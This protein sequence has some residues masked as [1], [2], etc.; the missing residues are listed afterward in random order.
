MNPKNQTAIT[1][2]VKLPGHPIHRSICGVIV[3]KPTSI[4]QKYD[5]LSTHPQIQFGPKFKNEIPS[6]SA[7][8]GQN[9]PYMAKW[10]YPGIPRKKLR[11]EDVETHGQTNNWTVQAIYKSKM[12]NLMCSYVGWNAS[13]V[14]EQ[15]NPRKFAKDNREA[16]DT[17][18]LRDAFLK[19]MKNDPELTNEMKK[20]T[21]KW[22]WMRHELLEDEDNVF[23]LYE[24]LTYFHSKI[25]IDYGL[26]P[27]M[28]ICLKKEMVDPPRFKYTAFNIV[29]ETA[30]DAILEGRSNWAFRKLQNTMKRTKPEPR[31][32]ACET[33]GTCV[34]DRLFDLLY[35]RSRTNHRGWKRQYVTPDNR[36]ILDMS[37][38]EIE[39]F[40]V[41]IECSD[42]CGCSSKCPRRRVQQGQSKHLVVYYENEVIKFGLRAVEKI[43][44]G[45]FVCEYTGVVVLPKKDVQRNESYDATINLLH[46]NL[47]IDSSQIGNLARFMSH[48]CEP[49]AV[50][51]ETHSRVKESDPLIPRISVYALKDIAVGEKIAISYYRTELMQTGVGIK[52]GCRPNCPNHLPTA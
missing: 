2:D 36:G 40:R 43:Q 5:E 44:K 13:A 30:M 14:Y 17:A 46:E 3:A 34:C 29:E 51:I 33:P 12:G 48:A 39:H 11:L 16:M 25:H 45:E 10:M 35:A 9:G 38:F 19:V 8:D 37:S 20:A 52:C 26:A 7:R 6:G 31:P 32:N 4:Q 21:G 24:D 15:F 49:N 22:L 41:I 27:L 47:V 1:Q 23:W 42:A 28:Y 50:M 18:N